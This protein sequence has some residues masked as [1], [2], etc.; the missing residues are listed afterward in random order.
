MPSIGLWVADLSDLE[1]NMMSERKKMDKF[2]LDF[3]PASFGELVKPP[4]DDD[5][6]HAA[7]AKV[8]DQIVTITKKAH[9]EYQPYVMFLIDY[10][11]SVQVAYGKDQ[12][13][14]LCQSDYNKNG[15]RVRLQPGG[16][17]RRDFLIK[18]IAQE[19]TDNFGE[20]FQTMHETHWD[21]ECYQFYPIKE[22]PADA[23]CCIF[24]REPR[25]ILS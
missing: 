14:K 2:P 17:E 4:V 25:Y 5:E 16:K 21:S 1:R 22:R 10:S 3:V 18:K 6:M 19:L 24:F 13:V 8:R 9:K 15:D 12:L 20:N 11:N 23:K 7:L